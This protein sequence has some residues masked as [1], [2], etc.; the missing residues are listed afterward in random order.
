MALLPA[1][2]SAALLSL[3]APADGDV[4]ARW[5]VRGPDGVHRP[6]ITR[7][8]DPP[9]A[10]WAAGH[11]G[12]DLATAP[13]AVV[14]AAAGGK[15]SFAGQVAGRGVLS[16][17]L[18]GTGSPPLRTTY[19]P[20]RPAVA[21]GERV[22]AGQAVATLGPGP[23]HCPGPCLHWGVL[24]GQEYVDPLSLL[25]GHRLGQGH[26]RLLPVSGAAPPGEPPTDAL[27]GPARPP[28]RVTLGRAHRRRAPTR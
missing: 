24:R 20:V 26:S 18:A 19:E 5:P 1:L 8:W 10:P 3:A 15:V 25:P 14:R 28:G 13:G 27:P 21:E 22:S 2:L 7:L 6:L 12:V 16:I 11:R 23:F 17:E 4:A 9:P